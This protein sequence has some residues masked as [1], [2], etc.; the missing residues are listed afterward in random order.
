[1]VRTAW[2]SAPVGS[3]PTVFP[4][5]LASLMF[6]TAPSPTPV[7]EVALEV[8]E[9]GLSSPLYVTAP[10]GDRRLFI[11]E[12]GG[13]V[14]VLIDDRVVATY[15]DIGSSLPSPRGG[16]QGLLGLAFHPNFA[17]NGRVFLSYTDAQ[18]ALRVDRIDVDPNAH[19]VSPANRVTV[20]RIPQP[21]RNHNGGMIL[22]GPDGYMY[23]GVG[24]GGGA[25]DPNG[26]GQNTTTL[27]GSILRIDVDSDAFPGDSLRNYAVPD[28][29]P[30][31]GGAGADEIWVYGL[32]NPWRFSFDSATGRL[33]I[34]DVGQG[35]REEVTVLGAGQ[36][37]INL[38]WN[39]LEGTRCYPSGGSCSTAGTALPQVEYVSTGGAAVT[40]GYVYRGHAL[41]QLNG[42]YFYA[43]FIRGWVRSF[44]FD[45]TVRNHYDWSSKLPTNL[46]SSFGV[47][48]NGEVYI[49]SLGGTLWRLTSTSNND[50]TFFYR[51]DGTYRY[52]DIAQN[53]SLGSPILAGPDYSPNWGAIT[54]VDLDGDGQDE[55]FFYKTPGVYAYY[56]VA[57]NARLG[58]PIKSG[59][60]YSHKWDSITSVDL[61][62]DG[63]DEMFFYDETLGLFSYYN[64]G[65][66]AVLGA[67]IFTATYSAG[68]DSI[69]SVDLDGDGHDEM[70][71]YRDDGT[72]K[73]YRM[74]ANGRFHSLL[75]SGTGYSSGWTSIS[76]VDL[77]GDGGDELLFYRN[78]GTFKYYRANPTGLGSLIRSGTG[79]STGWS[80][81][82]SVNLD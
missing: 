43:D 27:L 28:D 42:T 62:G 29:N 66:T 40:G 63:Q 48:A 73:Y 3:E 46:V 9:S 58:A 20:L 33:Y 16:E 59:T 35:S 82:T 72:F 7:P 60:G 68:W 24:D 47:D 49:V 54:S 36:R 57:D 31:V 76:A 13:K 67:P 55:M 53:A 12:Q 4:W 50:E 81:I 70:L 11:V 34:G 75:A 23:V 45:G 38:G 2:Q 80:S 17:S 37:G 56:A 77:D 30:F 41:P 19:T 61:D 51:G 18:G 25:G 44:G 52:Y 10:D 78:D 65:A 6:A 39:R 22:F 15:F 64:I 74:R 14:K 1:M 71:F 79:Y 21:A 5:L 32:R 26:H 69:T 8:V